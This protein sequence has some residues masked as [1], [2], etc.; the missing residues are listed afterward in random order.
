MQSRATAHWEG[1]LMSGQGTTSAASGTFRD[2]G[3]SW[4]ARTEG[5]A[6]RTTPEEL[7]AAAHASCFSM[8]LAH[9]LAQGGHAPTRLETTCAV[10]FGPKAGGGFEVRSSALEVKGW[11]PGLD[12]AA[13]QKAA[14]DA[15]NG[16]PVSAALKIRM[17]VT[18]ALQ[19]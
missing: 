2:A 10:E 4:K 15:K 11:V 14:E 3:L 8:A 6:S 5:A 18:A 17:S 9:G 16:C 12:A 7:L 13:F 19:P 1:D